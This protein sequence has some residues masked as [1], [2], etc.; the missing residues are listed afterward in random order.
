MWPLLTEL[1]WFLLHNFTVEMANEIG[2]K[3]RVFSRTQGLAQLFTTKQIVV[4]K[5][6]INWMKVTLI[7]QN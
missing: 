4:E 7:T 3:N 5:S 2:L 1:L 6:V